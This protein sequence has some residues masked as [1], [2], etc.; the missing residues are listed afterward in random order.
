MLRLSLCFVATLLVSFLVGSSALSR[1]AAP[2]DPSRA[3]LPTVYEYF[4]EGGIENGLEASNNEFR[5]NSKPLRIVSGAMHYFRI[6]PSMWRDR[7]RKLRATGANTVETYVSWNLH[8]PAK[9]VYDFGDGGNDFS[10]FLNVTRFI[11][12]AQE[13]DLLVLFRPGPYICSEWDFGGLPSYLQRDPD[14]KVRQF[15]VPYLQRVEKFFNQLLPRVA[16]LQFTVGGPI[17]GLQIENEYGSFSPK[18]KDYIQYLIL[19]VENLGFEKTLL[20][21][22]DNNVGSSGTSGTLPDRLLMTA[23]FQTDPE[24]NF[25]A[26]LEIQPSK[27]LMAMEFW[28]GW[29]DHWKENHANIGAQGFGDVLE[30]IMGPKYNGSV[31]FYMFHGGTNFAFMAGANNGGP[32][33][34][35]TDVTSYDY[36]SPLTEA[37]DY[38]EKYYKAMEIIE[39][40][41]F[42][43]LSRPAMPEE[44]S[45][46]AYATI[47]PEQYLSYEDILSQVPGESKFFLEDPSAMEDLPMNGESGQSYGYLVHRKKTP[48][49]NGS[50]LKVGQVKDFGLVLVDGVIQQSGFPEAFWINGER[51]V[52]LE[53]GNGEW[54]NVD[55]FVENLARVNFGWENDFLQ[56]KGLPNGVVTLDGETVQRFEVF[57][58]EFKGKWV[59]ALKDLRPIENVASLQAPLLVQATLEVTGQPEDTFVDLSGWTKGTLYI[60]GFNLGRYWNVGPQKT[61]YLPAHFLKTG[62]NTLTIFEE[63]KAGT[64][65][66]FAAVPNLG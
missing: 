3:D 16:H 50:V 13:E 53:S 37:G 26:L 7:L 44:S 1:A 52:Q 45:K 55:I 41:E 22:S 47:Q 12:M 21:S 35:S 25:D 18:S 11:E 15:N 10:E 27:P 56:K 49:N 40:Y 20:Y 57:A 38:E 4:T 51:E 48:V 31:N 29:F 34:I 63:L 64:E 66:N 58:L 5:L 59:R 46:R 14:M 42:P 23:N 65:I 9:D 28:S 6:P 30:R 19:L 61:L 39:K 32:D 62:Q 60:N 33:G 24:N 17:I 8:E 54:K 43:K 2:R 36:D